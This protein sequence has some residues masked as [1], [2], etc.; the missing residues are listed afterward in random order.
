MTDLVV[1]PGR[2]EELDVLVTSLPD[3]SR[4]VHEERP[5]RQ[6][7]GGFTYLVAYDGST[8][9]GHVVI[10]W[11]G[12]EVP[13]VR[14]HLPTD[15]IPDLADLLVHESRRGAGSRLPDP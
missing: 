12:N 7:R 13:E 14:D 6:T 11:T 9:V 8:P 2:S 3:R 15:R 10:T 5:D 1:R 4:R